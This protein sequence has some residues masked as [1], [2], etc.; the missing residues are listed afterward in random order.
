MFIVPAAVLVLMA[1]A[2]ITLNTAS[3]YLGQR[4]LQAAA[5]TAATDATSALN[6][7]SFYTTGAVVLD[8]VGARQ[9]ALLSLSAQTIGAARLTSPPDIQV[10][11]RQVCVALA[12]TVAPLLR[13]PGVGPTLV[14]ARAAAT[15]AGDTGSIVPRAVC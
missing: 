3:V 2:A 9:R 5:E 8:P 11:G 7:A 12:A 4:Q 15:A 1:L 10:S 13:F 6:D 14:H